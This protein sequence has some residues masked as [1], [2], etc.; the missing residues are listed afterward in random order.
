LHTEHA[1]EI[2]GIDPKTH[3]IILRD[4]IDREHRT[5]KMSLNDFLKTFN[6]LILKKD[7]KSKK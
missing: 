2:Q 1:Y 7:L 4:P 3:Q 6:S 5:I